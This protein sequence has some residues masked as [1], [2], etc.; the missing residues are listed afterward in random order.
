[1]TSRAVSR[2]AFRRELGE[3]LRSLRI[4]L[5]LSQEEVGF[6]ADVTQGSISNYENGISEIPLSVLIEICSSLDVRPFELIPDLAPPQ[7][8]AAAS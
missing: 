2:R 4:A 7:S 8:A 3:R 1:M 6:A 5:N